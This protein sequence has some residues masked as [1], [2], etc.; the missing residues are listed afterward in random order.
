MILDLSKRFD[1]VDHEILFQKLQCYNTRTIKQTI[2]CGVPQCSILGPLLFLLYIS[3][4]AN[5]SDIKVSIIFADDT[6]V[7]IQG[8]QMNLELKDL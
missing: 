3:D 2:T 5:V 8:D 4:I 1:I 6:N 7:F